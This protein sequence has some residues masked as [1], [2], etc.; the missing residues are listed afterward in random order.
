M[1]LTPLSL[2]KLT[3]VTK[4]SVP[5]GNIAIPNPPVRV[6]QP[7]PL[8]GLLRASG[9]QFASSSSALRARPPRSASR[10]P[11]SPVPTEDRGRRHARLVLVLV[12]NLGGGGDSG[13]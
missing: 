7:W 9:E 3:L 13:R 4:A 6:C 1:S 12:A 5:G 11:S 8:S 10:S 2:H